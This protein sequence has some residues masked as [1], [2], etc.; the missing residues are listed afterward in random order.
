MVVRTQM[1]PYCFYFI[2]CFVE[3]L[4]RGSACIISCISL[5]LYQL[6]LL[7]MLR[8]CWCFFLKFHF[9][10]NSLIVS[11]F[12]EGN[13]S[14]IFSTRLKSFIFIGEF[15]FFFVLFGLLHIVTAFFERQFHPIIWFVCA[16]MHICWDFVLSKCYK[17]NIGSKLLW[18]IKESSLK[19]NVGYAC[20]NSWIK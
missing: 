12:N 14:A 6:F 15:F 19:L 9:Q 3:I 20:E 11:T 10:L 5:P 13:D 1:G 18:L 2:F 8:K 16:V 17:S 4:L 7:S